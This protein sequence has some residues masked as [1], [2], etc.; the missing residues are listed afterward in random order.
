MGNSITFRSTAFY[1]ADEAAPGTKRQYEYLIYR[2]GTYIDHYDSGERYHKGSTYSG[3][4]TDWQDA[5][6]KIFAF[7]KKCLKDG[8]VQLENDQE[9]RYKALH[10]N[11][12][13]HYTTLPGY[14]EVPHDFRTSFFDLGKTHGNKRSML[15]LK[16]NAEVQTV[17]EACIMYE[18]WGRQHVF[19]Y[20]G[21]CEVSKFATRKAS[22]TE[23]IAIAADYEDAM[24]F[25]FNRVS[26][27]KITAWAEKNDTILSDVLDITDFKTLP[28]GVHIAVEQSL[29]TEKDLLSI[30][31]VKFKPC[32]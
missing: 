10:Y 28:I 6:R 32:K 5:V 13:P 19:S 12:H 24:R 16:F 26:E 8:K 31:P 25:K 29:K 14:K 18:I 4:C 7:E 17:Y 15:Y 21:P 30:R 11:D 1:N 3:A 2:G 22:F 9:A 23:A 27:K 20:R